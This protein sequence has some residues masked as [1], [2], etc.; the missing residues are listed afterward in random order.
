MR[1]I[2]LNVAIKQYEKVLMEIH[3]ARLQNEIGPTETGLTAELQKEWQ[4]RAERKLRYLQ[5][6]SAMLRDRITVLVK[7]ANEMARTI[8][9]EKVW[10]TP[11]PKADTSQ[12]TTQNPG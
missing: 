8:E 3:E 4:L 1:Q 9:K 2:E 7:E 11:K 12:P 5:D 10:V 6:T